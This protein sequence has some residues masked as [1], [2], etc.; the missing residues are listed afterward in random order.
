MQAFISYSHQDRARGADIK[1][2]LD[3]FG[4]PAFLAHDDI[5]VSREWRDEILR[6]LLECD[7]CIALLSEA[8]RSSDWAPQEIGI[9]ASR[10][11]VLVVP[12]SIDSTV[13]FGFISH[14]QS[15]PLPTHATPIGLVMRPIVQRFQEEL[16]PRII[17]NVRDSPGWRYSESFMGL[18]EPFFESLTDDQLQ[19]LVD[20]AISNFEVWAAAD[21]IKKYLPGLLTRVGDRIDPQRVEVLKY[22]IEHQEPFNG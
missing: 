1:K 3:H 8:F 20:G 9:V 15:K 13:S 18:L 6:R 17:A 19:E 4:I 14:L 12:L 5:E 10:P 16:I 7:I 11:E 2:V 22:Q 21:C